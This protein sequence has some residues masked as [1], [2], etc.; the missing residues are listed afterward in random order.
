MTRKHSQLL[1]RS[2]LKAVFLTWKFKQEKNFEKTET[3][4]SSGQDAK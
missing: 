4:I 3:R 1:F 2:H